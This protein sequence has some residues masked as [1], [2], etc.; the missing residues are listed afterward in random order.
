ME[1]EGLI[2]SICLEDVSDRRDIVLSR[3][4][5]VFHH[6]CLSKMYNDICP[7]CRGPISE[8]DLPCEDL[9]SIKKRKKDEKDAEAER[10]LIAL[11]TMENRPQRELLGLPGSRVFY[12]ILLWLVENFQLEVLMSFQNGTVFCTHYHN[13]LH[14]PNNIM[15]RIPCSVLKCS[16]TVIHAM[17][18]SPNIRHPVDRSTEEYKQV[19]GFLL[20]RARI[21]LSVCMHLANQKF[22]NICSEQ[23]YTYIREMESITI[24]TELCT[25]VCI[26][27]QKKRI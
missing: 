23:C 15:M 16:L 21:N 2:C 26:H 1:A 14:T 6:V 18:F 27:I 11:Q 3:C 7:T 8:G 19:M 20:P 25:L 22:P 12:M 4:K 9:G 24:A 17:I 13:L 10:E 5:H